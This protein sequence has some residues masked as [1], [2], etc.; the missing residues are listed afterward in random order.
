MENLF[1]T[2]I[3][4]F[5]TAFV[6]VL[7]STP[8]LIKVA[9]LKRL[10][11]EPGEAR[12]LHKRMVPTIGGIIIFAGTLFAFALW[13]PVDQIK[14]YGGVMDAVHNLKFIVA[15]LLILFFVGVKDDIV[16]TAPMKKLAAHVLVGL[17]LVLM[18][19]IRIKSMHGLFGI[20]ENLPYWASVFL[21]LFTYTVIVNAFN[22]IDGVDGLAAGIG[23]ISSLFFGFGFYLVGEPVMA[24][25][26]F[27]LAGSLGA[28]LVF[29]FN[30]ARIFMGDSGSLS[31]GL[32]ISVMA[33]RFIEFD[34]IGENTPMAVW[35]TPVFAMAAI[36]Y[37]LADTLRIFI[38]RTMR[39]LSPFAADRN[40][41]HHLLID[42]GYSHRKT[43]LIIYTATLS[44]IGLAW[45]LRDAGINWSFLAVGAY[46]MLLTQI[47]FFLKKRYGRR[48]KKETTEH[49]L[50]VDAA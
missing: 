40:H 37:P 16:G 44:V 14:D 7:L 9:F 34:N 19:D 10:F 5:L 22:L 36:V 27:S 31:I 23:I 49:R 30:P 33:I 26:G 39:G 24:A 17:I 48:N 18:A 42:S 32:L 25:L 47:P 13:F 41:L 46:T 2:I 21:S 29:N 28:F 15:A 43:V 12:K 11:D 20:T 45:V 50:N 38:Y 3:L 1:L 8:A 6:V 35:A 4:P